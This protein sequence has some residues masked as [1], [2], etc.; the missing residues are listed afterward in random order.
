MFKQ[1]TWLLLITIFCME[2]IL[3]DC[4]C[5]KNK[6]ESHDRPIGQENGVK[7][8][9]I[10]IK[11]TP[12]PNPVILDHFEQNPDKDDEEGMAYIPGGEVY[13]GT[14]D[15]VF[16]E[17]QESPKRSIKIKPFYM[18]KYEVSNSDFKKFIDATG[19]ETDAEHFGDSFVFKSFLSK[20]MQTKYEDFRV[21]SAPW[22]FKINDV[23]WR[24]PEG[25]KSNLEGMEQ[26]IIK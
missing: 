8:E 3:A 26:M 22:W 1:L 5:S 17:D 21:V 25:G 12:K 9:I 2:S 19:F 24:N 10:Q 16:K 18:D 14:D 6:R 11:T 4:G 20:K 13:I 7:E 23:S 15:P